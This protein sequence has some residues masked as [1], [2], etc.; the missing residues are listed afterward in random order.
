MFWFISTIII[1]YLYLLLVQ[2]ANRQKPIN[3]PLVSNYNLN[4]PSKVYQLLKI[5]T[6]Q[7]LRWSYASTQDKNPVIALLHAD[8]G[9]AYLMVIKDYLQ[10]FEISFETFEKVTELKLK[11]LE[12]YI[13]KNQDIALKKLVSTKEISIDTKDARIIQQIT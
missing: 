8:Y 2:I 9:N 4:Q 13:L 5:Y 1:L 11:D 3:Q 6:R 10:Y 12:S 7:C